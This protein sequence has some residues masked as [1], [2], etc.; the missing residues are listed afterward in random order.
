[1]ATAE[2]HSLRIP[3]GCRSLR[4]PGPLTCQHPGLRGR[5]PFA[6]RR[7]VGHLGGKSCRGGGHR[8]RFRSQE[9]FPDAM[10][11]SGTVPHIRRRRWR[12]E[13]RTSA[14]T[15]GRRHVRRP[16]NVRARAHSGLGLAIPPARPATDLR[17]SPRGPRGPAGSARPGG[18]SGPATALPPIRPLPLSGVSGG[19]WVFPGSGL[20]SRLGLGAA[21]GVFAALGAY[22]AAICAGCIGSACSGLPAGSCPSANLGLGVIPGKRAAQDVRAV[23]GRAVARHAAGSGAAPGT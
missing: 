20:S 6:E 7:T 2:R 14:H 12:R 13:A 9:W 18:A 16:G 4:S 15:P 17:T 19:C 22:A 23:A 1:M 5:Q 8:R 11:P 21:P 10:V 3:Y